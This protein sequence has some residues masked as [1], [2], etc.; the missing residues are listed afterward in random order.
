MRRIAFVTDTRAEY[1]VLKNLLNKIKWS[2]KLDLDIIVTGAHLAPQYG[3]TIQE[4]ENDGFEVS[5]RIP[6]L[7]D[8]D[9]DI[10][11]P[12]EMSRLMEGLAR[13]FNRLKPDILLLFGDRYEMLAS[14]SVAVGMH[15]PIAHIS[16]GEITQGAM[17]EQIRHAITKMAHIHFP[18]ALEYAQNI[19]KMGEETWRVFDVGDPGIENIKSTVFLEK[20]ELEKKI[21]IDIDS[22]TLLVTYHP[23][24]LERKDLGWQ[25]DNLINA[26]KRYHGPKII[27]YPNTDDGSELIIKKMLLYLKED[28]SAHL[29]KNLG[30]LAYLS[31]MKYCGAV[32]GNSSSAI[33]EAPFLKKPSVN[34]GNRQQG[35]LMADSIINCDYK[36]NNIY[37]AIETA[38]STA[39]ISVLENSKSL[40]GDGNTSDKIVKILE[41]IE[42]GEKLMKKRLE[43]QM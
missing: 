33:V 7:L 8:V 37:N 19:I 4:I 5:D 29:I 12:L 42:I 28:R 40:Y 26:L 11:V 18:G 3:Y 27:T 32:V 38:M 43:W 39:F 2:Q 22:K 16:G 35:R 17:D 25:V 23:V 36:E 9:T 30:S 1:G 24:T 21:G 15:I 10:R 41:D 34:I 31:T 20:T 13:S 14:A 6:S